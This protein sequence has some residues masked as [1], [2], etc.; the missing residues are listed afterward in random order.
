[1]RIAVGQDGGWRTIQVLDADPAHPPG[2]QNGPWP[3]AAASWTI[4][5]PFE[6]VG[7][8]GRSLRVP[9]L[10]L[11][12]RIEVSRQRPDRVTAIDDY[13]AALGRMRPG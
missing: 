1:V 4:A 6:Q 2:E 5:S 3:L 10:E 9:P 8:K 12:R 13:R 11:Q 7:W